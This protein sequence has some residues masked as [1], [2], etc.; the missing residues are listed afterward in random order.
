MDSSSDFE[1]ITLDST[2]VSE[3]DSDKEYEVEKILAQK[4]VDGL[5]RFLVKWKG[6]PISRSTWE[7]Q[8]SFNDPGTIKEWKRTAA[9]QREKLEEQFDWE[10]WDQKRDE[11]LRSAYERRRKRATLRKRQGWTRPYREGK[12]K[13]F[14]VDDGDATESEAESEASSGDPRERRRKRKKGSGSSGSDDGA[15]SDSL[16]R[17]YRMKRLKQKKFKHRRTADASEEDS[18]P[19]SP[20]TKVERRKDL[21]RPEK[22]KRPNSPSATL[23]GA[24]RKLSLGVNKDAQEKSSE[25]QAPRKRQKL[26]QAVKMVVKAPRPGPSRIQKFNMPPESNRPGSIKTFNS[27]S[28]VNRV[29][30]AGKNEPPPDISKIELFS[31]G[32]PSRVMPPLLPIVRRASNTSQ[33]GASPERSFSSI[34][35]NIA[36]PSSPE[37]PNR[38]IPNFRIPKRK[39]NLPPVS[40]QPSLAPMHEEAAFDSDIPDRDGTWNVSSHS[41]DRPQLSTPRDA[42]DVDHGMSPFLYIQNLCYGRQIDAYSQQLVH[43]RFLAILK[44]A[45]RLLL[46][47]KR[48]STDFLRH[49]WMNYIVNTTVKHYGFPNFMV[50]IISEISLHQ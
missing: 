35:Q 42:M 30:K 3:Q 7:P 14:V 21:V 24:T 47:V 31:P 19:P 22:R 12:L 44:L 38:A 20:R 18:P 2:E 34:A 41:L 13:G 10:E 32:H 9:R 5:D 29:M 28:Y 46:L 1:G 48:G 23:S 50:R 39:P 36:R 26:Q 40:I 25:R 6:Y 45:L 33:G 49:L 17:E 27:L 11:E 8:T 15:S 43:A 4:L 16:M 37:R